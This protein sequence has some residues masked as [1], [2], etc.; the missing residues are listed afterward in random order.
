VDEGVHEGM[1]SMNEMNWGE[2]KEERK[3]KTAGTAVGSRSGRKGGRCNNRK[4]ATGRWEGSQE[5]CT[6]GRVE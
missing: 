4:E 5:S 2:K 6:A 1:E 3:T